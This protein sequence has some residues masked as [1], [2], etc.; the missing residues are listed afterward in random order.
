ML[1]PSLAPLEPGA[2]QWEVSAAERARQAALRIPSPPRDA[3]HPRA[4]A[5]L[6]SVSW[7]EEDSL[8]ATRWFRRVRASQ[9]GTLLKSQG[10]DCL[11]LLADPRT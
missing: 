9:Q 11:Q 6:K 1:A 7:A 4:K 10:L 2:Q 3:P 5:R 8:T